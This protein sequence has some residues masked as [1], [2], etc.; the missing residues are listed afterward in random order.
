ME[1]RG[2]GAAGRGCAFGVQ[3]E[4]AGCVAAGVDL[5]PVAQSFDGGDIQFGGENAVL[6]AFEGAGDAEGGCRARHALG[7]RQLADIQIVQLNTPATAAR[8]FA[9]AGLGPTADAD[10]TCTGEI[11]FH[12]AREQ[13]A[14]R[15]FQADIIRLQ[16]DAFAVGDG[17]M[18]EMHAIEGIAR[19][20]LRRDRPQAANL[21]PV[22]LGQ[23]EGP[24]AIAV[25]PEPGTKDDDQKQ[26]HDP[27]RS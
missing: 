20:P 12:L 22:D 18:V 3:V 6:A 15:P 21:A 11:E 25:D 5:E 8:A 1:Q 14:R 27:A 10:I 7:E 2:E 9:R 23:D 24:S 13:R 26:G 16:P 4:L 19:E 17:E